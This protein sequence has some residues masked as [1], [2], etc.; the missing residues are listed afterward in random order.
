MS[1][2][3]I[4]AELETLPSEPQE[5]VQEP[6]LSEETPTEESTPAQEEALVEQIPAP[7]PIEF[8]IDPALL[9][10]EFLKGKDV[11]DDDSLNLEL[12]LKGD[13]SG[14]RFKNIL[15][16]SLEEL[17]ALEPQVSSAQSQQVINE[18]AQKFLDSTDFKVLRHIRQKA[19]G[20]EL[21]L[22]EN[23]Y[24]ALEQERSNAAARIIK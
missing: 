5:I 12:F 23:E 3:I 8:S 7:A 19:L 1:N 20:Q 17:K 18:E 2:E 6:A 24:L 11:S 13:S 16:P 4:D 14:W 15:A 21:S 9:V 10:S 22:S